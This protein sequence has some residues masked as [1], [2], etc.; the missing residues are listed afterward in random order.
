MDGIPPP[1]SLNKYEVYSIKCAWVYMSNATPSPYTLLVYV[2]VQLW[3]LLRQTCQGP[4]YRVAKNLFSENQES[5]LGFDW[6]ECQH[7]KHGDFDISEILFSAKKS[8][9]TFYFIF[10]FLYV[11]FEVHAVCP[12]EC[13]KHPVTALVPPSLPRHTREHTGKHAQ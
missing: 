10:G 13:P 4:S 1:P 3:Q 6:S 12:T 11:L 9:G 2:Y 7:A 5:K 8:W